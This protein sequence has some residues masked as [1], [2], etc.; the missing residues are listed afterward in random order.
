MSVLEY[1]EA[2]IPGVVFDGT[3]PKVDAVIDLIKRHS[4]KG[5]R[6][7]NPDCFA[8]VR[9]PTAGSTARRIEPFDGA[10][11]SVVCPTC[12]QVV[13]LAAWWQHG[14]KIAPPLDRDIPTPRAAPVKRKEWTG[15]IPSHCNRCSA[16][17]TKGFADSPMPGRSSWGHLCGLC[18]S[19]KG[20]EPGK[21]YEITRGGRWLAVAE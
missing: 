13:N 9:F 6:C 14:C 17:I 20:R 15:D 4:R 16:P 2:K 7:K 19:L 12:L 11:N 1:L 21:Y 18:W 8:C 3:F 5:Y 10:R